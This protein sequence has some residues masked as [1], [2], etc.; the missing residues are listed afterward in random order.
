MW[1]AVRRTQAKTVPASVRCTAPE[2]PVPYENWVATAAAA[3]VTASP[4]DTHRTD[5]QRS[6]P[7]QASENSSIATISMPNAATA[8]LLWIVSSIV[9]GMPGRSISNTPAAIR[10]RPA[11]PSS[12]GNGRVTP[13]RSIAVRRRNPRAMIEIPYA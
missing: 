8:A 3:P 7:Q 2:N 1:I 9:C 13:R 10:L 4:S 12:T 5:H 6:S 11:S